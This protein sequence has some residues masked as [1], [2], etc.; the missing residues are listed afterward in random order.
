ME[1]RIVDRYRRWFE[2]EKD[3][4]HKVLESIHATADALRLSPSFQR[5]VDLFAHM[6][7]AR[8]LWLFR[9][10][11]AAEPP[12]ELFPQRVP[13]AVLDSLE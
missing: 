12:A 1:A 4:H 9:L 11:A 10:G 5:A 7:A 6:M 3:A 2:Y 13:V 8:F